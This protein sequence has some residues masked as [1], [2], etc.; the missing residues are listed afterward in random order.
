MRAAY[1]IVF[2]KTYCQSVV[3]RYNRQRFLLLRPHVLIP[4]QPLAVAVIWVAVARNYEAW[5]L[6]FAGLM[7]FE[8]VFA[9]FQWFYLRHFPFRRLMRRA[10]EAVRYMLTEDGLEVVGPLAE[11]KLQ[12]AVY[13]KSVRYEDGV[14]LLRPGTICWLPDAAL[15][16]ATV[17][18][19]VGFLQSKTS[20]RHMV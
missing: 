18:E 8:M 12:W 1:S 13:P 6:F 17:D 19:V 9:G 7:A 14:L 16:G 10:G 11:G 2:D 20:M 15:S 4:M 5:N 3:A